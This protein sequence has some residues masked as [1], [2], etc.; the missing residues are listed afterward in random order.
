[1]TRHC[2]SFNL[3]VLSDKGGVG[4]ILYVCAQ[5]LLVSLS[6]LD[7]EVSAQCITNKV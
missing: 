6:F 3:G 5:G 2:I 1:M 4:G 7:K